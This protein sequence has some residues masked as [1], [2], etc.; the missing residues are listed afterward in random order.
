MDRV[1]RS[2]GLH[3]P[4]HRDLSADDVDQLLRLVLAQLGPD[5]QPLAGAEVADRIGT[6]PAALWEQL[7]DAATYHSVTPLVAPTIDILSRRNG[8]SPAERCR[9]TFVALASHHR[10]LASVR[11]A[12]VD[13][14]IRDF[15]SA[16]VP[17]LLL[18][19]GALAHLI[20]PSPDV[21]SMMDLDI[22]ID[23]A[24]APAAVKI[25]QGLGFVFSAP[26]T[27]YSGRM[28]H[29][30]VAEANIGGFRILMDIHIDAM[31]PN[32]PYRLTMANLSA[33]PRTF[34]RGGGPAGVTLG[35]SDM[36]HHLTRHAFEP[37]HCVR[38][39]HLYDIWRYQA[40]FRPHIDWHDIATSF[41]DV[42]VALTLIDQVFARRLIEDHR[43]EAVA[44]RRPSGT[45]YGMMPLSDIA[46]SQAGVRARLSALFAPPDWWLHGFYGVPPDK[47]LLFCRAVRHPMMLARWMLKRYAAAAG[48]SGRE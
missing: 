23:A 43:A 11:E 1:T 22:L 39:V 4:L 32:Q 17:M 6:I 26:P 24:D 29:V 45:G 20:Y 40:I 9:R 44:Q 3:N 10:H 28:H 46:D 38:L 21:R 30:P 2:K 25:A 33:A 12:C 34:S 36:L 13:G 31:S 7:P 37:A 15:T 14:L 16:G 8:S 35:H 19:G 42:L 18:K 41:P 27:R 5:D 48:V 47:S